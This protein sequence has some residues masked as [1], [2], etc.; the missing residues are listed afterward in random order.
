MDRCHGC[1][2]LAALTEVHQ[3]KG[4]RV[5]RKCLDHA[6]WICNLCGDRCLTQEAHPNG[7]P[8]W[9]EKR[10]GLGEVCWSCDLAAEEVYNDMGLHELF[11]TVDALCGEQRD[12]WAALKQHESEKTHDVAQPD[13]ETLLAQGQ[14]DRQTLEM[15]Q[16]TKNVSVATHAER[17]RLGE[18]RRELARVTWKLNEAK[19]VYQEELNEARTELLKQYGRDE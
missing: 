14:H 4:V 8:G 16:T 10:F 12:A 9:E 15:L 19:A 2:A 1:G 17:R 11:A 18:L 6:L 3:P 5:C 13:A 7:L